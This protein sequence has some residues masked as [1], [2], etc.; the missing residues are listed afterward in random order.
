MDAPQEEHRTET[1]LRGWYLTGKASRWSNYWTDWRY[2]CAGYEPAG[3]DSVDRS[4]VVVNLETVDGQMDSLDA[5]VN[6]DFD[7]RTGVQDQ[8]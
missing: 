4:G 2:N 8:K 7:L 3:P 6:Q 1:L 5:E